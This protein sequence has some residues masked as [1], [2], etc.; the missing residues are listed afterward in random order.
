M[1]GVLAGAGNASGFYMKIPE[2]IEILRE[3][4][5][6]V[7][8][9]EC[10]LDD[11]VFETRVSRG[12]N[13]YRQ[14]NDRQ[15]AM[16]FAF[17]QAGV[18]AVTVGY[19]SPAEIDEAAAAR[20]GERVSPERRLDPARSRGGRARPIDLRWA[21]MDRCSRMANKEAMQYER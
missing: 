19:K 15:A 14:F 17:K 8:E 6:K 13:D 7:L 21:G 11:M 2:T 18:Q 3:Y 20:Q 16:R 4:I 1:L 12:S 5:R 9:H 10:A